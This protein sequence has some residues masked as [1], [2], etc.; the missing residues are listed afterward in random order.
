MANESS[1]D[2][3]ENTPVDKAKKQ[4]MIEVHRMRAVIT[5]YEFWMISANL[6][7]TAK[8]F[9]ETERATLMGSL[10][11]TAFSFEA[12]LNHIGENIFTKVTWKAVERLSPSAKMEVIALKDLPK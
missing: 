11:F 4:A 1:G 9:P 8:D 2:Q 3:A 10:V 12:F 5:Y 7:R 6:L